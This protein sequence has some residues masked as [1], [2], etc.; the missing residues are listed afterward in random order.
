MPARAFVIRYPNGDF[1]Y[2]FTRSPVPSIGDT[3]RRK[4]VLWLVTR[5]T[6]E[7]VD[8]VHVELAKARQSEERPARG[9]G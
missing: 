4:R 3:I 9:S 6:R 1:E 5:I 2:D 7:V 8:V